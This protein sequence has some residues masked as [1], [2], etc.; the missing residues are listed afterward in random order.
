MHAYAPNCHAKTL[1]GGALN[2]GWRGEA[3]IPEAFSQA[4]GRKW[5][6]VALVL[7]AIRV[8]WGQS[9]CVSLNEA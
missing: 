5:G 4:V 2:C 9:V 6:I 8:A 3:V 1:R 7:G